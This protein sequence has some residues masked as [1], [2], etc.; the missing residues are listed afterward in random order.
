VALDL[1][2]AVRLLIKYPWLTIVG[3]AA[4]AFGIAAGVGGFE[5]RTQLVS[6]VLPL[7]DGSRI[8]GIRNWDVSRNQPAAST[9]SDFATFREG[10]TRIQEV[11]AIATSRRNLITPD[12]QS[13]TVA[14]AAM[15]ASAFRVTRVAPLVGRT[16]A[17]ADD[18]AGAPAVA[19]I[20]YELW[21]RR[22]S[23]DPH[24]VGS[25]VRLGRE[26]ATVVGVMPDGF[27]FPAVHNVWVPLR[28]EANTSG[29]LLVGR[30]SP[31]VSRSQAQAELRVLGERAADAAPKTDQPL[32]RQ[33]VPF[34][35]LIFD[36]AAIRVGLAV[37]NSFLIILLLLVS[38]NVALLMFARAVTR[39]TEIAVRSALG[40]TRVR[41]VMQL[42]VE[43]LVLVSLAVVAGL[44]AARAGLASLLATLAADRGQ[45]LPF[46]MGEAL[47][48]AS[49]AYAVGLTVVCAVTIGVLPALR[50]T[51]RRHMARLRESTAGGGGVQFGVVWGGIIAVQVAVTLMFP[52][53]AFFFHRIV[54]RG[55]TQDVGVAAHEYLSAVFELDDDQAA[56]AS[57]DPR[58]PRP[59]S[60]LGATYEQFAR[61]VSAEAAVTGVTFG[62][63][64]PGTSHPG[65]IIEVD[66]PRPGSTLAPLPEVSAAS[67]APNFFEV[68]GA[69]V[70]AGR[71]FNE[72]D[73]A[74]PHRFVIVNQSFTTDVLGGGSPIGRR[75]RRARMDGSH[76][77]GPWLEI[78]GVVPD[79]GMIGRDGR[80]A[81]VY[82]PMSADT[83]SPL[84]VAIHVRGTPESFAPRLRTV[85]GRVNPA[86]QLNELVRLDTA[87]ASGWLESQYL[88][89]AL[90]VL[91]AVA[92]LLSLTAIYAVMAY[93][94][95][96]RTREIGLRAAL[97]ADRRRVIAAIL[98]RP[99]QQ[100]G[101]GILGGSALVAFTF[102]GLF[103][104]VP[105]VAEAAVIGAYCI[106]M[107]V[108]CLLACAIPTRRALA[109]EPA[110]ALMTDV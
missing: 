23:G 91:S 57:L 40:A 99:L 47:T 63:P 65:W 16:L 90:A 104:S 103:N 1:K 59:A 98:R 39:E 71:T 50:V 88:S 96:T 25:L 107:T 84:R 105:T 102:V 53:A 13:E 48:P 89:R 8:V 109:I 56:G 10:L 68:L 66:G 69:P 97:G 7:P 54:V 93:S 33:V 72:A 35:W 19:V 64:L 81:G 36:P 11:S 73:L 9:A 34:A 21:K 20:G 45:P 75:I 22:F 46:W 51:G 28:Y 58:S 4:M 62:N 77:P 92:L 29:L 14:V 2:L 43:A 44:F 41:T 60:Q 74:S 70:L 24:V 79:L 85:A 101:C 27:T 87:G 86:L 5:L 82:Q 95:S 108:I 30:L 38:A 15:T 18:A 106:L 6:P 76:E 17:E 80:R 52:A 55:Q 42:F 26:Q 78:V 3:C 12:G 100:I 49:V 83:A 67:V 61:R 94:V 32:Q 31:H 37:A 110:R